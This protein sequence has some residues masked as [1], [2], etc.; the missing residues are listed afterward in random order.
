M[1]SEATG[2]PDGELPSP[3]GRPDGSWI[4]LRAH[5]ASV[6]I[7]RRFTIDVVSDGD[8][9]SDHV[10]NV[11]VV[12]SELVTNGLRAAADLV[13]EGLA[14]QWRHHDRPVRLGVKVTRRWTQ[15]SVVD[16]DPRPLRPV[17]PDNSLAE[18]GRGLHIVDVLSASCWVVYGREGK[19]IHAVLAAPGVELTPA[20]RAALQRPR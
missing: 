3:I 7:A 14:D 9:C 2:I 16:P 5:S 8:V 13:A 17:D 6:G 4:A 18:G 12:V 19:T 10:Y 1:T 15:V 11:A 20:E